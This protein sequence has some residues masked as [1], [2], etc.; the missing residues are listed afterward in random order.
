MTWGCGAASAWPAGIDVGRRRAPR[1]AADCGG[2]CGGESRVAADAGASC[3]GRRSGVRRGI[4]V[5]RGGRQSSSRQVSRAA[6]GRRGIFWAVLKLRLRVRLLAV[7]K[8]PGHWVVSLPSQ[9]FCQTMRRKNRPELRTGVKN[10]GQKLQNRPELEGG[11]ENGERER[12]SGGEDGKR[13]GWIWLTSA[14]NMRGTADCE[15]ERGR[16][17]EGVTRHGWEVPGALGIGSAEQVG[18]LRSGQ[19]G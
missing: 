7:Y 1:V 16:C 17:G 12:A 2:S 10:G 3:G 6:V 19:V 8:T 15:R 5:G 4:G 18:W 13:R 11:G 14:Q 9:T